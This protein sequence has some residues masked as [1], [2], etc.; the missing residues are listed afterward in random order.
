[1]IRAFWVSAYCLLLAGLTVAALGSYVD[2]EIPS[3]AYPDDIQG[4]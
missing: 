3:R 4:P 2:D 1:M